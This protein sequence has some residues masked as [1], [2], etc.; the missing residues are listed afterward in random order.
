MRLKK[1]I[2]PSIT[3]A[4]KR[5]RSDMGPEAIILHSRKV[6]R[7]GLSGLFS[8]PWVE[9]AAAI[10]EKGTVKTYSCEVG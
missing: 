1:Y 4:M 5:V 3:D 8:R 6:R 10:D 2:S 9:V 7:G